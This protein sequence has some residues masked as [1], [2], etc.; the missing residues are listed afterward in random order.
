MGVEPPLMGMG[1]SVKLAVV[2]VEETVNENFI[3]LLIASTCGITFNT[4]KARI[5]AKVICFH[6]LLK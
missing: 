2:A 6:H 1:A 5:T 4:S 3:E